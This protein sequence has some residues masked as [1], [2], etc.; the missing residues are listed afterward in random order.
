[1]TIEC[2]DACLTVTLW[3][4]FNKT[5]N[6]YFTLLKGS[7]GMPGSPGNPG[8]RG[9]PGEGGINS[10]GTKGKIQKI[11]KQNSF[12]ITQHYVTF[13]FLNDYNRL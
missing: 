12:I 1:M 9:D 6:M 4:K 3:S 8:R 10:K 5:I 11:N 2:K 7:R 13:E